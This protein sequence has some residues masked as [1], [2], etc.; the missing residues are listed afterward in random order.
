M[1]FEEIKAKLGLDISDFEKGMLD[2]NRAAKQAADAQMKLANFRRNKALEEATDLEKIKILQGELV[3]LYNLRKTAI[4]G[5]APYLNT[6]LEIEK[7]MVEIGKVRAA[8]KQAEAN[9]QKQIEA[10]VERQSKSY[11]GG[12]SSSK[13]SGV[14]GSVAAGAGG[15]FL[16]RNAPKA[17]GLLK[18]VGSKLGLGEVLAGLFPEVAGVASAATGAAGAG[19]SVAA[20][21]AAVAAGPAVALS[22]AIAGIVYGY[23]KINEYFDNIA[24]RAKEIKQLMTESGE[25]TRE[26]LLKSLDK[27]PKKKLKF[28]Q[29]EAD[30]AKSNYLLAFDI[31]R[32]QEG[33]LKTLQAKAE[34]EKA[35]I[36]LA[37]HKASMQESAANDAANE[38]ERVKAINDQRSAA[39]SE[40]IKKREGVKYLQMRVAEAEKE[41]N[42]KGLTKLQKTQ[43]LLDLDKAREELNNKIEDDKKAAADIDSKVESELSDFF[44]FEEKKRKEISDAEKN[45]LQTLKDQTTELQKQAGLKEAELINSRR[46]AELPT[47][48]EVISGK[49]SIGGTAKNQAIQLE[50][51]RAK[52]LQLADAEQR[53]KE[54]Y[55]T[56]PNQS[57]KAAE[58]A[59]LQDV[60]SR[61]KQTRS[62]IKYLEDQLGSKIADVNPFADQ[63]KAAKDARDAAAKAQEQAVIPPQAIVPSKPVVAPQA[64]VPPQAVVPPQ[65]GSLLSSAMESLN[66]VQNQMKPQ[67][68]AAKTPLTD[69]KDS[70]SIFTS[71]NKGIADLNTKLEAKSVK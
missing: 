49:R 24:E 31:S 34:L 19:A 13:L 41:A 40:E 23:K 71:I 25:R 48:G 63:E 12:K 55:A 54:A 57:A 68:L 66:N 8:Q 10:S 60:Q 37:D 20:G 56:A 6:Q 64:I 15:G 61:L 11:A 33:D 65:A 16:S 26:T 35:N 39:L 28:L 58:L 52:E 69:S 22:V 67:A 38:A 36:A 21:G 46:Q 32:N 7:K 3:Q 70:F 9:T 45:K 53:A 51:A 27:D 43:A 29:D 42:K 50:R 4:A 18:N 47:M 17:L 5:S 14:S 30:Q 2:A 59:N 1:A 62:K 44:S